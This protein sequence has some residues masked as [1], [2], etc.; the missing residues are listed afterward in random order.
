MIDE[1]SLDTRTTFFSIAQDK[2]LPHSQKF[3]GPTRAIICSSNPR[4]SQR[5]LRTETFFQS[6]L[7]YLRAEETT[8]NPITPEQPE[9]LIT[10]KTDFKEVFSRILVQF[11]LRVSWL[12]LEL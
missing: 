10:K 4:S 6:N 8:M 5:R 11:R 9:S 7:N 12:E 1:L 3:S 2:N